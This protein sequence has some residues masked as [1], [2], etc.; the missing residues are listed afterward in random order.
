MSKLTQLTK[1]IVTKITG[2]KM[3]FMIF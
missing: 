3:Y 1:K 2:K